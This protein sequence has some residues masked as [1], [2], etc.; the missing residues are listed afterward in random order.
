MPNI[1]KIAIIGAGR[2]GKNLISEYKKNDNIVAICHHSSEETNKWLRE[3]ISNVPIKTL[4]EIVADRSI[5]G[6]IVATPPSTHRDITIKLLEGGKDVCVE[7][8]AGTSIE[9]IQDM[10][11]ISNK[12]K[13]ILMV[14][15]EF[16]YHPIWQWIIKT[17]KEKKENIS[18]I[19]T[20]W[21]KWGSFVIQL[22]DNLL[23]HDI[24]LVQS[25]FIKP[26]Q[27]IRLSRAK[28]VSADD[29][30][31]YIF[32]ID[33]TLIGSSHINRCSPLK[34]KIVNV[35]GDKGSMFVWIDE[36]LYQK[37]HDNLIE[38]KIKGNAL[39]QEYEE[40]I[41]AISTRKIPQTDGLFAKKVRETISQIKNL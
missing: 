41:H 2:W 28:V 12:N 20:E 10:I 1:P 4:E 9:D 33:N 35:I 14:G 17:F 5:A 6:A 13:K 15:Y 24:S 23:C 38:I 7:K 31:N 30:G 16:V 37:N 36:M 8:P 11:Y 32:K 3:N 39:K 40:F 26:I 34:H 21:L 29:I 27:C 19:S 22:E 18:H 25:V